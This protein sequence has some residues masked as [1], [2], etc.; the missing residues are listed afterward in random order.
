MRIISVHYST[1]EV[2]KKKKQIA[3]KLQKQYLRSTNKLQIYIHQ[4]KLYRHQHFQC[5]G[6][7]LKHKILI[8]SNYLVMVHRVVSPEISGGFFSEILLFRYNYAE[9]FRIFLVDHFIKYHKKCPVSKL[10]LL[11]KTLQQ[12]PQLP[13]CELWSACSINLKCG[14]I[15][16]QQMPILSQVNAF[17]TL[18]GFKPL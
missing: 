4:Y 17:L 14:S 9:K 5:I 11:R 10:L 3:K 15:L 1:H 6:S 7:I 16:W 8:S 13:W 2:L 12:Q 18:A